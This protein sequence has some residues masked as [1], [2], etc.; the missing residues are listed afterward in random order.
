MIFTNIQSIGALFIFTGI[1]VLA[2]FLIWNSLRKYR[3]IQNSF[4]P[5]S[6]ERI[7][8]YS[9]RVSLISLK[10][11]LLF[12]ALISFGLILLRPEWGIQ[13]VHSEAEGIDVVFALDVSESMKALDFSRG[14]SSVNRLDMAKE[15][16]S[17]FVKNKPNHRFGLVIFAGEAFPVSPLTL[18]HD[19]FLTFLD[20]VS[21]SDIRK[22]GTNL[23][24]ALKASYERLT[25]QKNGDENRGKAIV[26]IT[27]GEEQEGNSDAILKTLLDSGIQV[28]SVGIGSDKGSLI[29]VGQDVF[30]RM[31]YKTHK[32]ELVRTKLNETPLQEIARKTNGKYFHP[33]SEND[34]L[35]IG[36]AVNSLQK[37]K[38]QRTI[39]GQKE[40][41][42]PIFVALG[43]L[44]FLFGVFLPPA[45]PEGFG[46]IWKRI[47]I[48]SKK[49]KLPFGLML[50][51]VLSG[52]NFQDLSFSYYVNAG[53]SFAA[54]QNYEDALLE[55]E[56]ATALE[57]Q[58]RHL[59][60]S[61]SASARYN[62]GEFEKSLEKYEFIQKST[63]ENI[64]EN[65]D[66]K[67]FCENISYNIGNTYYRIGE[68]IQ[69][70]ENVLGT[71]SRWEKAITAYEKAL[72]I[73]PND[74]L[75]QENKQ[76]VEEKLKKLKE[77]QQKTDQKNAE[78][79][80]DNS[81]PKKSQNTTEEDQ[82]N[83]GN[84]SPNKENSSKDS[85]DDSGKNTPPDEK[86]GGGNE[87][88]KSSGDDSS[89]GDE[90]KPAEN[91]SL[92]EKT[93][94][95]LK[96]Y[97]EDLEKT[98]KNSQKYF[99]Q[100][101][102]AENAPSEDPFDAFFNDPFFNMNP[103]RNDPFFQ[104]QFQGSPESDPNQKDW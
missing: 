42:Y 70:K 30:G 94:G 34:F 9:S 96:K 32:G 67:T 69:K 83:N 14:N 43:F 16:I 21:F 6:L 20:G 3:A 104:P 40:A 98:E 63:C 62:M 25:R 65:E 28:F 45:L 58:D 10:K 44:F 80:G 29:Q 7:Q 48:F 85:S 92:D 93:R 36:N 61:N 57:T 88:K 31:Q 73:S 90:Q 5:K 12:A 84:T 26:L 75:V 37:T 56:K 35:E 102:D 66:L 91:Q 64:S 50:L 68:E 86:S 79:N 97:M 51:F 49:M 77:E 78:T 46:N 99:Q 8:N 55:Y 71:I 74:A 53:N 82:K 2:G 17:S 81:D 103:F 47:F 33:E 89:S 60:E 76:F 59:S 15:M 11:I 24:E 41:Q 72:E 87:N 100:K 52:C 27:D 1:L 22:Q 18:D 39:S 4:S 23:D 95:E 38:I 101:P 13:K 19:T 54:R